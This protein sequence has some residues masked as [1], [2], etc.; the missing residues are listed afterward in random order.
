[1]DMCSHP[2]VELVVGVRLTD[3]SNYLLHV[4]LFKVGALARTVRSGS[5]TKVG[6]GGTATKTQE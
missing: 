1:M 6:A 3:C 5:L 4:G 2:A